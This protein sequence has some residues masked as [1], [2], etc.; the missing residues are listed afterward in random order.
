MSEAVT[1]PT[2]PSQWDV[3]FERLRARFPDAKP[4]VLFCVHAMQ[5]RP[6]IDMASLKALAELHSLKV[7]IGSWNAARH[8]LNPPQPKAPRP[9]PVAVDPPKPDAPALLGPAD[10][11]VEP[12]SSSSPEP[13]LP[14]RTTA[15]PK[16]ITVDDAE[17]PVERMARMVVAEIQAAGEAKAQRLRSAIREALAVIKQILDEESATG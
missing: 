17:G 5:Q 15:A 12:P 16:T 7:S 13:A 4:S 9:A 2:P 11:L 1:P 3:E 10:Q 8:L 14:A 6:D